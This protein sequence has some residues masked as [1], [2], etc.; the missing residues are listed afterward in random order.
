[1]V[2]FM[3]DKRL[4]IEESESAPEVEVSRFEKTLRFVYESDS[5]AEI[6]R[7]CCYALSFGIAY[8]FFFCAL[9][10]GEESFVALAKLFVITGVP[11]LAVSILRRKIDAKRPY[12]VYSFYE[13]K[14]KGRAGASFPSRHVFSAFVIGVAIIPHNLMLGL[15][16]LA[17]GV[18]IA[19]IRVL[20][21]IH[22]IKDVAAGALIGTLSGAI[23]ILITTLI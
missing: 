22:F 16:A 8:L 9:K 6:L 1:M 11:F 18:A 10:I 3:D 4:E 15:A 14:P 23:G 17:M 13:R 19:V 20:L 2:D 12:E 7:I 5:L 21:G